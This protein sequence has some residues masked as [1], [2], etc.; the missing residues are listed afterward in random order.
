MSDMV[1]CIDEAGKRRAGSPSTPAT[2]PR[3]RV[4]VRALVARHA[5][6][7]RRSLALV[8]Y[9]LAVAAILYGWRIRDE[10]PFTAKEGMG[11]TLGIVGGSMMLSLLIYPLRKRFPRLRFLGPIPFW[12][13]LHMTFG[14]LGPLCVLYHAGFHMGSTNASVALVC[15]L[16]VSGSGLVGRYFYVRIHHGLYGARAT[17]D[18]LRKDT[19]ALR[20]VISGES[21]NDRDGDEDPLVTRLQQLEQGVVSG[22]QFGRHLLG[23]LLPGLAGWLLRRRIT[24]ILAQSHPAG[25]E[26]VP[27]QRIAT[28]YAH[29]LTQLSQLRLFERLFSLWHL[30]H[31]PL[32]LMLVVAGLV[33][34]VFVHMY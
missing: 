9:L 4:N 33:H 13:R 22:R 11:Y 2:P 10:F 17:L 28:A 31:L 30:L 1:A 20:A 7:A 27:V 24:A 15:M 19:Q 23:L 16:V 3:T 8:G 29:C 32:F 34:V 6:S 26:G 21:G 18:Q 12:F 5:R 14:I 25:P